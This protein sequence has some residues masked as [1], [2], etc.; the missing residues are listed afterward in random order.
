[1][2]GLVY[3]MTNT[4]KPNN[5]NAVKRASVPMNNY[6]FLQNPLIQKMYAI[7]Q[8]TVSD[9]DKRPI[10][11]R[12]F[13]DTNF[14][15][16]KLFEQTH[17]NDL[18]ALVTGYE[19]EQHPQLTNTNRTFRFDGNDRR[20]SPILCIDVEPTAREEFMQLVLDLPVEYREWST[21]GGLHAL[22]EVPPHC[23]PKEA[24]YLFKLASLQ[25][26]TKEYECIFNRH[27]MT[28]TKKVIE[29]PSHQLANPN[30]DD[31]KKLRDFLMHLVKM[32]ED[33]QKRRLMLEQAKRESMPDGYD[34]DNLPQEIENLSLFANSY[35]IN[36]VSKLTPD[37]DYGGNKSRYEYNVACRITGSI[38]REVHKADNPFMSSLVGKEVKELGEWDYTYAC[39]MRLLEVLP[40]RDKHTQSRQGMPWLLYV[41]NTATRY[42]LADEAE[43]EKTK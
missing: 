31:S 39:Y 19:I 30:S 17:S 18:S 43:K 8:W 40:E 22:V 38:Y 35:L 27:F 21:S 3:T 5:P 6:A 23:L 7:P 10:N 28:F 12:E 13:I 25:H 34:L 11:M 9:N 20:E 4:K 16:C 1:M 29:T 41:A 15:R 14:A 37:G 36:E 24:E 42:V 33:N 26:E 2:K 32:D